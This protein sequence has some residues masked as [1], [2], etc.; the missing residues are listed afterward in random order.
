MLRPHTQALVELPYVTLQAIVYCLT[1]FFLIQF[2][3]TAARFFCGCY[4]P[5]IE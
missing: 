5:K 3:A 4:F 2:E 1:T